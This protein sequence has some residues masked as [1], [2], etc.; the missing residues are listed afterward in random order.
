MENSEFSSRI[1]DG[2]T[3]VA[4]SQKAEVVGVGGGRVVGVV[5][6]GDEGWGM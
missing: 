3:G 2:G 1:G 5:V 6:R 4:P